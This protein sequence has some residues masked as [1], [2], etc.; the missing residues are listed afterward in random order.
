MSA[1]SGRHW[2]AHDINTGM[3]RRSTALL[4]FWIQIFL[5]PS[6]LG[7]SIIGTSWFLVFYF[8]FLFYINKLSWNFF[9][10]PKSPQ[11]HCFL[12]SA[13]SRGDGHRQQSGAAACTSHLPLQG[14]NSRASGAQLQPELG[15]KRPPWAACWTGTGSQQEFCY[16]K[17]P[18]SHDTTLKPDWLLEVTTR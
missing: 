10:Q 5:K 1:T 9:P 4:S 18:H 13:H 12:N 15:G 7:F 14:R 8:V 6:S 17:S 2:P 3:T 11:A 16:F